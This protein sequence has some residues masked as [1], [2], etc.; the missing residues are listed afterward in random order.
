MG[1]DAPRFARADTPS[2]PT[3]DA[4]DWFTSLTSSSPQEFRYRT[5][6]LSVEAKDEAVDIGGRTS[7]AAGFILKEW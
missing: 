2:G 6:L 1:F 4:G 5:A 3:N 7:E